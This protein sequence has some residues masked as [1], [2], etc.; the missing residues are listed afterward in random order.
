MSVEGIETDTADWHPQ[1]Q[2][3]GAVGQEVRV[4]LHMLVTQKPEV[5]CKLWK[6]EKKF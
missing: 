4:Q 6:R 2:K 1:S 5:V 3:A